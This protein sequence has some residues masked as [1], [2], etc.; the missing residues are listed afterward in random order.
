MVGLY[1]EDRMVRFARVASDGTVI[2]YLSDVYALAEF[3]GRGL[4]TEL[5]REAV[6]NG[7]HARLTW[8]L[9][10][11]DAHGLYQRFGF[12]SPSERLMER[13]PQA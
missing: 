12:G 3:Q 6:E 10:T 13:R 5:V 7:P 11:R 1:H 4:G 8:V 2:A 9:H